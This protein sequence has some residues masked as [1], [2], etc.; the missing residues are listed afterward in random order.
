MKN[1]KSFLS[2]IKAG[3]KKNY[4]DWLIFKYDFK[5]NVNDCNECMNNQDDKNDFT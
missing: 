2:D 4:E 3:L 5:F 1:L